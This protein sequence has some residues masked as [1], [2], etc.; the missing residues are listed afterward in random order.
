MALACSKEELQAKSN[1]LSAAV[2]ANIAKDPAKEGFWKQKQ[3]NAARVA[4]N[5]TDLDQICAAF[6]AAITEVTAAK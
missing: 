3:I 6:D 1:Q 2:D 5:T 4:E